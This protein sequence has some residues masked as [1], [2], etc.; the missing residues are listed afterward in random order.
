M[1][2]INPYNSLGEKHKAALDYIIANLPPSPTF[3]NLNEQLV[4]AFYIPDPLE[5]SVFDSL[6]PAAKTILP[7]AYNGYVN[8]P[9]SSN[10]L[11][12]GSNTP[13][14]EAQ[15]VLIK[16]MLEG[17]NGVPVEAIGEYLT[18][19]EESIVSTGLTYA[20]Q[21]PLLIA[22][23][24]GKAGYD[25]W[26]AQIAAPVPSWGAYLNTNPVINYLHLTGI[27][28]ATM[29]AS[30]LTYGLF[31]PPQIAVADWYISLVASAGLASGK[32][33]FGWVP[34]R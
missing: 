27:L 20:A 7:N 33:V 14:T 32:V 18:G 8:T 23:A 12:T 10:W 3:D 4:S 16:Q 19:V 22:V 9:V 21:T 30:L 26:M 24:T 1:K 11:V 28:T 5:P 13:Y 34:L 17:I 29:Q 31:I 25:Y 15:L 6:V 2:A